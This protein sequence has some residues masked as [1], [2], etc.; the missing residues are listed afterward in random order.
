MTCLQSCC[1]LRVEEIRE[2]KQQ[3]R[4]K[5]KEEVVKRLSQTLQKENIQNSPC[6][7]LQSL[8]EDE[9]E[10]S[11]SRLNIE[12]DCEEFYNNENK[13]N[14]LNSIGPT[15]EASS[16]VHFVK[17]NN[18]QELPLLR[19]I[20]L[21]LQ[22]RVVHT[23]GDGHCYLRAIAYHFPGTHH[24]TLKQ[25]LINYARENEAL[26]K[27]I[28]GKADYVSFMNKLE[29]KTRNNF[30]GTYHFALIMLLKRVR[31][32]IL[33]KVEARKVMIT[34]PESIFASCPNLYRAFVPEKSKTIH[35]LFDRPRQH[36]STLEVASSSLVKRIKKRRNKGLKVTFDLNKT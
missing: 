26:Y 14:V 33:E 35:V 34:T 9:L 25:E 3:K 5:K 21:K 6:V 12:G 1:L 23:K 29:D 10:D 27:T 36:F 18:S 2:K 11:I 28:S 24:L 32:A 15:G 20:L 17:T 19:D 22:L 4:K 16:E 30:G 13:K 7:V 8:S 31:I